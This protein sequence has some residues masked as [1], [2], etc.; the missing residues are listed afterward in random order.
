MGGKQVSATQSKTKTISVEKLPKGNYLITGK[1]K[2][3]KTISE[4]FIK[5]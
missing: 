5:E 4:K 1:N 3:D 2:N